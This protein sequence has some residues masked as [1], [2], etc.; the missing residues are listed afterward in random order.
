[1]QEKTITKISILICFFHSL[2]SL[3]KI[4]WSLYW[5]LWISC[6]NFP[7]H[8]LPPNC[9]VHHIPFPTSASSSLATVVQ[10]GVIE[11]VHLVTLL[12]LGGIWSNISV[13]CGRN[14]FMACTDYIITMICDM[15]SLILFL[16][17]IMI[18]SVKH[19]ISL[20]RVFSQSL[21]CCLLISLAIS[22]MVKTQCHTLR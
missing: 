1:M 21:P 13:R 19:L 12:T 14:L 17:R 9:S 3:H 22:M 6:L 20:L 18:F 8:L 7:C 2:F 11:C 4:S 10:L 5:C 15:S 16:V